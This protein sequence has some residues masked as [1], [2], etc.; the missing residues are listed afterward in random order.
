MKFPT[1]VLIAVSPLFASPIITNSVSCGAIGFPSTT[2]TTFCEAGLASSPISPQYNPP[3]GSASSSASVQLQQQASDQLVI[4]I[5]SS[6]TSRDGLSWYQTQGQ[7][8]DRAIS[9][10]G[11]ASAETTLHIDLSTDGPQRQ[12]I[13]TMQVTPI[14]QGGFGDTSAMATFSIGSHHYT[15]A[16]A[17]SSSPNCDTPG[18]FS[19]D[20]LTLM[21]GTSFTF[22]SDVKFS[23]EA[24]NGNQNGFAGLLL[25]FNFYEADG[26]TPVLAID[27]PDSVP[28]PATWGFM[29]L[30]SLGCAI[31]AW[32]KSAGRGKG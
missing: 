5:L 7:Y 19:T 27:P 20:P 21:L 24:D 1:L 32:R 3:Y 26:I 16:G 23:N 12:G 18:I 31:H 25:K 4:N 11:F 28:E 2:G 30:A 22:D 6:A 29:G 15:C 13:F 10:P 17:G 8:L 9:A 14:W